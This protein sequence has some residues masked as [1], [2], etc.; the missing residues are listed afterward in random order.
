MYMFKKS[1]LLVLSAL[2]LG[3]CS[4][5]HVMSE[6]E[7]E[8]LDKATLDFDIDWSELDEEPQGVTLYLFPV[9]ENPIDTT[10]YHFSYNVVNHVTV[11]VPDQDYAVICFNRSETEFAD[12]KFDFS[13]FDSAKVQAKSAEEMSQATV[14]YGLN[15]TRAYSAS[16]TLNPR[17]FASSS[18]SS[19]KKFTRAYSVSATLNP[20]PPIKSMSLTVHVF[21]LNSGVTLVGRLT[22]L[23]SGVTLSNQKPLTDRLDQTL[24]ADAWTVTLP[25]TDSVPGSLTVD[26][27]TFG[28]PLSSEY[29]D[30]FQTRGGAADLDS[31]RNMLIIDFTLPD[32]Q[33]VHFE[34]DVTEQVRSE[35][36]RILND[37]SSGTIDDDQMKVVIGDAN[38]PEGSNNDAEDGE[39]DWGTLILHHTQ[40]GTV[41]SVKP[42][43]ENVIDIKL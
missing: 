43:Q 17:I 34:I 18:K 23:S 29:D 30:L 11:H 10:I 31:V 27:G 32:G 6:E 14:R 37:E 39:T 16:A 25:T 1:L 40:T 4:F 36:K 7:F 15:G 13:S 35:F 9:D 21:G 8:D 24:D 42:W 2:M 41:V 19:I 3:S 20:R 22:N 28:V 26:F 12:L 38:D 5:R 33:K